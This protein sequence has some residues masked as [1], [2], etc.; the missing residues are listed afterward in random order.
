MRNDFSAETVAEL[1]AYVGEMVSAIKQGK[2][3]SEQD[4]TNL[5]NIVEFLNGLDTTETGSHILEGVAQGM[6]DAGWDSDAETVASNLEAA[7]NLAFSINSP[8]KRVMPVGGNVAEGVGAGMSEYDF[9]TEAESAASNLETAISAA[10]PA[11]MLASYG[12][13]GMQGIADAMT[14]YS[15]SATGSTVGSNVKSAVDANLNASTLRSVGVNA[16]AGLKAGINAGRSGVISA[17]RSAA[18]AAVSAAK[19]TL[20]IKSPSRVFRDEVG[21][22]AMKGFGQGVMTESRAQAQIIR[23]AARYLTEE[24]REGAIVNHTTANHRTYN[25]NSTVTLTGNTFT[26]RDEQD[27]YALATE[28]A[29]LTKRQQRGKGLRMA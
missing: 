19:S 27:I 1:S 16:M 22:M 26:I 12:T 29:A 10:F 25:Q 21:V 15:M 13:A 20:K 9:S 4:I 2:Q 3:V 7:L 18:Q 11:A 24:A 17:M 6:T 28:I 23:N 5:Q 14:G 8:S